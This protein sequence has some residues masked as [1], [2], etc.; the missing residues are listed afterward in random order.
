MQ[1]HA[2][3]QELAFPWMLVFGAGFLDAVAGGAPPATPVW[4]SHSLL[5]SD[6]PSSLRMVVLMLPAI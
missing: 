4:A 3:G 6:L 1:S 5:R 2:S